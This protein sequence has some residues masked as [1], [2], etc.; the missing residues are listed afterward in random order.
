MLKA[1]LALL[2]VF[3]LI[4]STSQTYSIFNFFSDSV[5]YFLPM[6][7][8]YTEAQKLK[9]NPILAADVAGIMIH[10]SWLAMVSAGEAVKRKDIPDETFASG[11]LGEGIGIQ[12]SDGIVKAPFAGTIPI[13][14]NMLV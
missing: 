8:A 9:C 3:N 4:D 7:L 12:P 2:V 11:V 5:F 14:L 10:P 1:L 6:M 13:N